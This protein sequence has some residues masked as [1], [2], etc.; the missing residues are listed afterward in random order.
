MSK[1]ENE[2]RYIKMQRQQNEF[3]QWMVS[4]NVIRIKSGDHSY[5]TSQDAMWKNRMHTMLDAWNY[6]EREFIIS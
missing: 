5:W 4:D 2:V 1:T 3:M 6:Y